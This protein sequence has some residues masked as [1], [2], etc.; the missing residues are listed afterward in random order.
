M[1][2]TPVH[3]TTTSAM[4]SAV[5]TGLLGALPAGLHA[6]ELLVQVGLLGLPGLHVLGLAFLLGQL[7]VGAHLLELLVDVLGR[8]GGAGLVHAHAR[9]GFV[10]QVDGLVGQEAVRDVARRELGGRLEGFIRDDQVVVLLV[11]LADALQDLDRLLDRRLVDHDGLEAALQGGVGF[12]VLAVFVQRGRA[13]A[14]Q[15]AARQGRLEDVGGIHRR[16]G[17][18]GTDQHVELVDEQ[19]RARWT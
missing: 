9:G 6:L 5:T 8:G 7:A 11:H 2:G 14:L 15:F 10:D 18:T 19:D 17:R 13:D 16:A 3:M 4:S 1:T 12:D